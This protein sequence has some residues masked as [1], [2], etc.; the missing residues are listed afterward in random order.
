MSPPQHEPA[1]SPPYSRADRLCATA[2]GALCHA[3]FGVAICA[4]VVSLHEG[5]RLG[6][7]HLAGGSA[8]ATNVALALAFPVLHSWLLTPRGARSLDRLVPR[9]LG[10]DVRTTTFALIASLQLLAVFALWSPVGGV[11][12]RADGAARVASELLFACSWLLLGRAM[13]DAGLAVQTGFLGWGAVAQGLPPH[14][15]AF[16]SGGLFRFTRHPIYL[17]F[18][19]TLWSG[20]VFTSDRLLLASVWTL[21]CLGGPLLKER[22]ILALRRQRRN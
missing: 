3:T 8:W 16:A 7:G 1:S 21:Y 6:G 18:T 22:R 15:P 14:F 11:L 17:A 2:L 13:L 12:W 5:L 20:P 10:R 9:A 19:L 4:M